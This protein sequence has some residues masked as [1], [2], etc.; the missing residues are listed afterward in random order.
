MFL[1]RISEQ[2]P[3]TRSK[4]GRSSFTHLR[5]PRATTVAARGRFSSSAISPGGEGRQGCG[6]Q[7]TLPRGM[8][9]RTGI[10][11]PRPPGTP[12]PL[13]SPTQALL[14]PCKP[15]TPPRTEP[16]THR[17]SQRARGALPPRTPRW[18]TGAAGPKPC[19]VEAKGACEGRPAGV[20][21]ARVGVP[22]LTREGTVCTLSR[23]FRAPLP[24]VRYGLREPCSAQGTPWI[25]PGPG[26]G[27]IWS[28][29]L[30]SAPPRLPW[31]T[32]QGQE[33]CG[34]GLHFPC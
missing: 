12:A 21:R 6:H 30:G 31:P 7:G 17:S 34:W 1:L 28:H 32:C 8:P 18:G 25:P 3:S 5:G 33:Q 29:F 9:P 20:Q 14:G 24:G 13:W 27:R 26:A 23:Q 4:R 19:P 2:G 10:Q 16:C 11:A 22:G 15:A